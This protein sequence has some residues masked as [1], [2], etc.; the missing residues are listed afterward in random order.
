MLYLLKKRQCWSSVQ[1]CIRSAEHITSVLISSATKDLLAG[2][3]LVDHVN[4]QTVQVWDDLKALVYVL[5][6]K[7]AACMFKCFF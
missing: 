2:E 3:L 1:P 4:S 6:L 7:G 5:Q